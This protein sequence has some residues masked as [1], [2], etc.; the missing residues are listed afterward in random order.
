MVSGSCP[1]VTEIVFGLPPSI[2]TTQSRDVPEAVAA[3]LSMHIKRKVVPF[4]AL[5]YDDLATQFSEGRLDA[6]WLPPALFVE[7][8][9]TVGLRAVAAAE[10]GG[11][12]GYYTAFFTLRGCHVHSFDDLRG[13]SVGWVDP[14]S[15]AGYVFP[16]L[17]LAAMGIDPTDIFQEEV[18]FRSHGAVVR[19]VIGRAVDVGATF[20]H[21]DPLNP[22][23]VLRAGWNL[24]EDD[25][26]GKFD[27]SQIQPLAPFGPLP[28]DVV[29]ASR[30][31]SEATADDLRRAFLEIH[32]V[33][34]VAQAARRQF[35]TGRFMPFNSGAYDVLRQAMDMAEGS[36]VEVAS[37]LRPGLL[38]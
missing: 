1:K 34:E 20:V 12:I 23:R 11:G 28:A 29:A 2:L 10:R 26:M 37:S 17:Q 22:R 33:P 30:N 35:G 19:G 13:R 21:V 4:Q 14:N 8:D 32:T 38:V 27:T 15:A 24:D 36:G 16:R 9:R 3:F 5:S 7:V 25:S 18:F 6:A 31:L